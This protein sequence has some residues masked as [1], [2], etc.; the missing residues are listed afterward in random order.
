MNSHHVASPRAVETD[1][2]QSRARRFFL[3]TFATTV[4]AAIGTTLATAAFR[5][6]RPPTLTGAAAAAGGDGVWTPLAPLSELTGTQ[7]SLRKIHIEHD[8][9]WSRTRAEH[10]VYVLAGESP[11]VVSAICPHEGCEVAW[12]VEARDFFC[13][14]HDSRF[15]AEGALLSGPAQHNLAPLPTR[16]EHGIL[17]VQYRNRVEGSSQ[18]TVDG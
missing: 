9:G 12:R 2:P 8:G 7:P 16:V 1:E 13:P 4:F 18:S 6:L 5:F 10:A 17:Q 11:R 3:L 15:D 14:C